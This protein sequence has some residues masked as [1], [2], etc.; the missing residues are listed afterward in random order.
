M[1]DSYVSVMCQ[2]FREGSISRWSLR[3]WT[4]RSLSHRL[5]HQERGADGSA[6]WTGA[7][8]DV[9]SSVVSSVDVSPAVSD[10]PPFPR[11]AVIGQIATDVDVGSLPVHKALQH[12]LPFG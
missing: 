2:T 8:A 5:R 1:M 6:G 4:L 12:V 7:V 9:A 10:L 11:V 3:L